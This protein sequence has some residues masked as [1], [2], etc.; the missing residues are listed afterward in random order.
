[1]PTVLVVDDTES[2]R[3]LASKVVL[4]CGHKVLKAESGA[5]AIDVINKQKPDLFCLMSSCQK[6]MASKPAALSVRCRVKDVPIILV[7]SKSTLPINSGVKNRALMIIL[8]SHTNQPSL[9]N[10]SVNIWDSDNDYL[11][12]ANP[13]FTN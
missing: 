4:S 2:D 10:L 11:K 12:P 13:Y 3:K 1:M 5:H 9:K 7:T 6:W 8:L